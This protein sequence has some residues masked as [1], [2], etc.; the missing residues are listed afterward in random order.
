M[1]LLNWPIVPVNLAGTFVSA[2][3]SI[4]L[5]GGAAGSVFSRIKKLLNGCCYFL[6]AVNVLFRDLR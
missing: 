5:S 2:K 1:P 3:V 4:K 6:V